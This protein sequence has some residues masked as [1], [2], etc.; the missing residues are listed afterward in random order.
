MDSGQIISNSVIIMMGVAGLISFLFPLSLAIYFYKKYKISFKSLAVGALVFLVFQLLTRIPL[1]Q[2]VESAFSFSTMVPIFIYYF[3]LSFS[4][5]LFE[6]FGRFL[7]FSTLLKKNHSYPDGLSYGIGHGGFE[8]VSLVGLSMVNNI[9]LSVLINSG[10]F[11]ST[12]GPVV[13][14]E[15]VGALKEIFVNLKVSDLFF[16]GI[17][18]VIAIIAHIGFT[19]IVLNGFNKGKKWMYL[20]IAIFAHTLFNIVAVS[21][22]H[23]E[24]PSVLIESVLA[25]GAIGLIFYV[26]YSKKK[27]YKVEDN[28]Q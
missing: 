28:P 1:L 23:F 17:E 18:R 11:E 16:S 12:L 26:M 3:L 7:A 22:A 25:I 15:Q 9:I 10:Q 24:V 6:E 8:A 5:G 2:V 27:I 4:A 14:M 20:W 19:F 21:L 13:G